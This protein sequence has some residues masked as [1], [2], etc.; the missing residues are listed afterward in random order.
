MIRLQSKGRL[1]I[2]YRS[3]VLAELPTAVSLK[4]I[5][6]PQCQVHIPYPAPGPHSLRSVNT[7]AAKAAPGLEV[8]VAAAA[9]RAHEGTVLTVSAITA[10]SLAPWYQER[11]H[12]LKCKPKTTRPTEPT[13][14]RLHRGQA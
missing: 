13:V 12:E 9:I 14:Q 2:R 6:R 8:T 7:R 3:K 11:S 4:S 1:Q 10:L 5:W